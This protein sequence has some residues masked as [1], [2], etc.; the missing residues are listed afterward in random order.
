L[1]ILGSWWLILSILT[2]FYH[3]YARL[4]LPLH[5]AGWLLLAGLL[6]V[7]VPSGG[8]ESEP[9]LGNDDE[10]R[11]LLRVRLVILLIALALGLAQRWSATSRSFPLAMF[12]QKTSALRDVVSD[13]PRLIPSAPTGA[14]NLLVLGR[15]PLSFY[16]LLQ[17][18]YPFRLVEGLNDL[19]RQSDDWAIVDGALLDDG[20]QPVLPPGAE[21]RVASIH[22]ETLDPVTLLDVSPG[23]AIS[24]QARRTVS[25]LVLKP[26]AVTREA[27]RSRAESPPVPQTH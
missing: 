26:T 22:E 10:A 14:P 3:P 21:G 17:S 15:R 5:A 12:F 4:W 6:L 19:I 13:L 2:P 24:A 27:V 9:Q 16:L 23:A 8:P 20:P 18:R 7:L 1:R 25:I 11:P